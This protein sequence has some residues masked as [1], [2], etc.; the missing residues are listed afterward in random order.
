MA[1]AQSEE[2]MTSMKPAEKGV[3][4]AFFELA[5]SQEAHVAPDR[6]NKGWPCHDE[7]S[8][9]NGVNVVNGAR[10]RVLHENRH[11]RIGPWDCR[12]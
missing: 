7:L 6:R 12:C 1:V 2:L 8:A 11:E 5:K 10:V 4:V 9:L 3:V